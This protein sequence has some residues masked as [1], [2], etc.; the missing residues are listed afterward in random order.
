M[1]KTVQLSFVKSM[2]ITGPRRTVVGAKEEKHAQKLAF[3]R[4]AKLVPVAKESGM[5]Q[6]VYGIVYEPDEVDAHGDTT[7]AEEIRAACYNYMA[8][9]AGVMKMNHRG[10]TIDVIVLENYIAP[11]DFKVDKQQVKRGSWVLVV[12][13]NDE[14][15]WEKIVDG[16]LTGYSFAGYVDVTDLENEDEKS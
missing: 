3:E 5:E 13:V 12:R 15:I 14:A 16:D 4:E 1:K 2:T 7:T 10:G 11:C 8:S 9:Y 6:V